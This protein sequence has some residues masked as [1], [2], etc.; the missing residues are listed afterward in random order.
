MQFGLIVSYIS[1]LDS[2]HHVALIAGTVSA[3][4]V[5][6]LVACSFL[7]WKFIHRPKTK[8]SSYLSLVMF[9][10]LRGFCKT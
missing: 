2:G 5:C 8:G 10:S 7:W 6:L 1:D 3:F 9:Q 4:L